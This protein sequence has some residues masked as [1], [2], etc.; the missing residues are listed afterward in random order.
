MKSVFSTSDK[1]KTKT[2]T[3]NN[4]TNQIDGQ[5]Q[6]TSTD[7]HET[8]AQ[9]S[10]PTINETDSVN[11]EGNMQKASSSNNVSEKVYFGQKDVRML[12]VADSD[13]GY[14]EPPGMEEVVK[15]APS[16]DL[17][18]ATILLKNNSDLSIDRVGLEDD[19]HQ[20]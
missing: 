5:R 16:M 18:L 20:K 6:M 19:S 8:I 7:N 13:H 3:V 9:Y 14:D 4:N 1:S 17:Q 15:R 12:S 11:K 10:S 2:K